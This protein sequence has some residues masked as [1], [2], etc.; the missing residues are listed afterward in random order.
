MPARLGAPFFD[1]YKVKIINNGEAVS[2]KFYG[3][4][5]IPMSPWDSEPISYYCVRKENAVH[6]NLEHGEKII[7]PVSGPTTRP[8]LITRTSEFRVDFAFKFNNKDVIQHGCDH[9]N[10]DGN[11]AMFE[12]VKKL[13]HINR[14][15]GFLIKRCHI[16][17]DLIGYVPR[18]FKVAAYY[19]V[20]IVVWATVHV[21]M[22]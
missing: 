22:A 11:H 1:L 9:D 21:K 10:D 13:G 12:D 14:R 7:L 4:I 18:R 17:R 2:G 16:Q 6:M 5:K 19:D 20:Y 8:P 3:V 15:V